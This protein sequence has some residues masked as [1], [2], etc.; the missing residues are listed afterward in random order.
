MIIIII[1]KLGS[2]YCLWER[3]HEIKTTAKINSEI[4][5]VDLSWEKIMLISFQ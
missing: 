1:L 3:K 2:K 4:S 5:V